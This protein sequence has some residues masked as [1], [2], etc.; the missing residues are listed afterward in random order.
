MRSTLASRAGQ[1]LSAFTAGLFYDE[2]EAGKGR[3][4]GCGMEVPVAIKTMPTIWDYELSSKHSCPKWADIVDAKQQASTQ[5]SR[6]ASTHGTSIALQISKHLQNLPLTA[7]HANTIFKA[8]AFDLSLTDTFS[9]WCHII[10][11]AG[12]DAVH[13][14]D[15]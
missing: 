7:T 12:R 2:R 4:P 3:H 1:S 9:G 10:N 5:S 15:I 6:W 14:L 8:C 11:D 13:L